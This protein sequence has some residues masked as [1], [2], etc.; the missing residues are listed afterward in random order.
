[1]FF[2]IPAP[3]DRLYELAPELD[4]SC[5][6]EQMAPAR[7]VQNLHKKDVRNKSPSRQERDLFLTSIK[8]SFKPKRKTSFYPVYFIMRAIQYV[9]W[10]ETPEEKEKTIGFFGNVVRPLGIPE[11]VRNRQAAGY[12]QQKPK[13]PP[14]RRLL[15]Y[16]GKSCTS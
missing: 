13:K 9:T 11:V 3:F 10:E 8:P 12:Y 7:T 5:A 4:K 14:T 15:F 2:T 6:I 1:M 16:S